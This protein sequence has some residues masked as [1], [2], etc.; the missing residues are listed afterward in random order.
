MKTRYV[1][2]PEFSFLLSVGILVISVNGEIV[3]NIVFSSL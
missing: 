3:G 2:R 1:D